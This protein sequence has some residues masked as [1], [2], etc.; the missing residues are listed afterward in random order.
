MI[1]T[2]RDGNNRP[3]RLFVLASEDLAVSENGR[4]REGKGGGDGFIGNQPQVNPGK[5]ASPPADPLL[6]VVPPIRLD[7]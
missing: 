3:G 5:L 7:K 4:E 1:E 2:R 6:F